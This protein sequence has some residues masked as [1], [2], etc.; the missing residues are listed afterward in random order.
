M[1]WAFVGLL[2]ADLAIARDAS[3]PRDSSGAAKK[4]GKPIWECEGVPPII[5][6]VRQGPL[7][8]SPRPLYESDD[9]TGG[10]SLGP[11]A[12]QLTKV[13][14]VEGMRAIKPRTQCCYQA[15]RVPGLA[16]AWTKIN[17]DGNV[18]E[19]HVSGSLAG[20][21]SGRCVEGAVKQ[22]LFPPFP[23]PPQVI[24]YPFMLR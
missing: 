14:I 22:A 13:D 8:P 4:S 24:I 2:L 12:G 7:T 6:L 1:R 9:L 10:P 11:P 19:T 16:N 15:F 5:R 23:G 3:V 20:T 21:P 18:I 17:G